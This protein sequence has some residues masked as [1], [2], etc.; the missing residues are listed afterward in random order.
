LALAYVRERRLYG[1]PILVLDII[2]GHLSRMLAWNLG[3]TCL[4]LKA[5]AAVNAVGL[6]ASTL[7]AIAKFACCDLAERT[8]LEGRQALSARA[9]MLD[10]PYQQVARDVWLYGVFDGTRHVMLDQIQQRLRQAIRAEVQPTAHDFYRSSVR[11]M[12]QAARAGG[13]PLAMKPSSSI[14]SLRKL[15]GVFELE[16]LHRVAMALEEAVRALPADAWKVQSV[17]FAVAE[18]FAYLE[19]AIAVAELADPIRRVSLGARPLT[20]TSQGVELECVARLAIAS[21][22]SHALSIGARTAW[23]A[24]VPFDHAIAPDL[25]IEETSSAERSREALKASC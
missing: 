18:A 6:R 1:A 15:D 11:S 13:V 10:L 5:A 8:A 20:Q 12:V 9:L 3:A 2:A 7:T 14:E 4:G 16:M 24:G 19:S 22:S 21:L 17:S 23:G 25:A